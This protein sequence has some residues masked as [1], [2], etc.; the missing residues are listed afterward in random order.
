MI[1]RVFWAVKRLVGRGRGIVQSDTGPVQ[2]VQLHMSAVEVHDDIPRIAEY[3][4]SS[5]PPDG[6]TGVALFFGGDRTSGV[7]IATQHQ[8]FRFP[9]LQKGESALHDNL[10]Q[11]VYLSK[12]GIVITDKAGSIVHMNGDGTGSMTFAAGLTINANMQINGTLH[13]TKNI[14]S[15]LDVIDQAATTPKSMSGMRTENNLHGHT[16]IQVGSG[17]SGTTT[18]PM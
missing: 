13:A 9:N 15:D 18:A 7:V 8:S 1:D 5:C 6:F 17:T 3:G 16:G 12:N 11:S 10:G 2:L 4:L 14:S